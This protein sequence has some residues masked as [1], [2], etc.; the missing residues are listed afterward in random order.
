LEAR[1][2]SGLTVLSDCCLKPFLGEGNLYRLEMGT[3]EKKKHTALRTAVV[4]VTL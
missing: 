2:H 1:L 3:S 4:S